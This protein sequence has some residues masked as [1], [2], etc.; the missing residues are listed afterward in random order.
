MCPTSIRYPSL[1][2][3]IAGPNT[4][5]TYATSPAVWLRLMNTSLKLNDQPTDPPY[6]HPWR[7]LAHLHEDPQQA[8]PSQYNLSSLA[9]P[10]NN[11]SSTRAIPQ[12]V[13]TPECPAMAC[14]TMHR[15]MCSGAGTMEKT[16]D[17]DVTVDAAINTIKLT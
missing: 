7:L 16:S 15:T 6:E 2:Y 1:S 4:H 17:L 11:S 10:A 14:D 9:Q 5:H 3:D 13:S 8:P 12:C